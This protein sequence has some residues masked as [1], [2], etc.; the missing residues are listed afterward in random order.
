M[1]ALIK[2]ERS[3]WSKA[4]LSYKQLLDFGRYACAN[5]LIAAVQELEVHSVPPHEDV[6]CI[7]LAGH[8]FANLWKLSVNLQA[9]PDLDVET[10][11]VY[12]L[13]SLENLRNFTVSLLDTAAS[14][15]PVS[16]KKVEFPAG[17][18]AAGASHSTCERGVVDGS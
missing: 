14:Y 2:T 5:M 13:P 11:I 7:N 15:R 17:Y 4:V 18:A 9:T 16:R 1:R 8:F 10:D 3:F 12:G 6:H